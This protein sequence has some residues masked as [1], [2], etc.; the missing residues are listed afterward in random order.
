MHTRQAQ[1]ALADMKISDSAATVSCD[2]FAILTSLLP[3]Q[4]AHILELGCGK[5]EKTRAI[6][7]DGQVASII[8]LEVDEVQYEKNL[9]NTRPPYCYFWSRGRRGNP[10]A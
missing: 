10:R 3:L 8:A 6:A 7:Q 9:A 4:G 2:E 1:N 5:A